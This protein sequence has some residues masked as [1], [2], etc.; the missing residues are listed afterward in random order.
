MGSQPNLASRSE[1]VSI[2]N[3]PSKNFGAPSPNSGRKNINS[4]AT[5][6]RF[7]HSTPHISG[8]KRRID[9]PKV[10]VS[11]YNVSP[12]RWPTF[13]DLWPRNGW[14]LFRHFD[15]PYRRPLRCNHHSCDMSNASDQS[16]W[17]LTVLRNKIQTRLNLFSS[18]N[19]SC[20]GR[21]KRIIRFGKI[22]IF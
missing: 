3:C 10:L 22:L 2:Y 13:R 19:H 21:I 14:D 17:Y 4:L 8:M 12:K 18:S 1:V 16:T 20:S 5:F 6:S 9:E 15:L 7:P 11:I